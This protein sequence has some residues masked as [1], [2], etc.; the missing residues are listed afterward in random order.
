M[1]SIQTL[2]LQPQPHPHS[3]SVYSAISAIAF[4]IS[5]PGIGGG[6]DFRLQ[7]DRV[8]GIKEIYDKRLQVFKECFIALFLQ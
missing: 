1:I 3:P 4:M 5:A 6:N 2:Q 8:P 7:I